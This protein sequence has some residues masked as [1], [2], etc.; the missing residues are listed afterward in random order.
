MQDESD[1]N[2][3]DINSNELIDSDADNDIDTCQIL[4]G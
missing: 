1:F 4:S 3:S 2:I